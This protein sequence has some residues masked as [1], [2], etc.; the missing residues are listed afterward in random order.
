M[1]TRDL[2]DRLEA[3]TLN[4]DAPDEVEL[5]EVAER[6]YSR[7]KH[8]AGWRERVPMARRLPRMQDFARGLRWLRTSDP[9]AFGRL[10]HAVGRYQRYLTL[11]GVREGDVPPRYGLAGVVRYSLSQAT[12]LVLVLP[13]ALLGL[14]VWAT[15]FLITRYVVPRFRPELDQVATYKLATAI[16]AFPIWLVL[17]EVVIVLALGWT[18]AALSL[19]VLPSAGLAAIA[20]RDRQARVREDLRVFLRVFLHPRGRDRLAA[21]R[22]WLIEEFDRLRQQWEEDT[23]GPSAGSA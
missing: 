15:P 14:V 10:R 4:V 11:F 5:V 8:M 7:G 9:E 23:R 3:V 12:Y 13:M 22:A 1:L 19:V 2:Q 20:W 17:L 16:L 18:W 6:L 21:Q